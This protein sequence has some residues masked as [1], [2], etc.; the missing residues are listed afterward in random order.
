MTIEALWAVNYSTPQGAVG[1]GVV[2]F[3]TGR[4]FGGDSLYHYLGN[5]TL[6][7]DRVRGRVEIIHRFGPPMN[8][9]GP[10]ERLTLEYDCQMQGNTMQATGVDPTN[11]QRRLMMQFRRLANLL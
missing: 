5:Y 4:I 11:P 10:I 3:E 9:F 8:I 2:V 1:A 7:G 6:T